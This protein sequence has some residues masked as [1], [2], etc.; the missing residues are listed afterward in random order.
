MPLNR[1]TVEEKIMK[2]M[3]ADMGIPYNKIR[4]VV[5]NGQSGFTKHVI[6]SGG[7][8]SVRWPLFGIFK[9]KEKHLLVRDH[10]KGMSKMYQQMFRRG[11]GKGHIFDLK[12]KK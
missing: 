3:S 12:K 4:D 6:E 9:L 7:Y 10:M 1:E 2:E 5:I 11:L 8:D